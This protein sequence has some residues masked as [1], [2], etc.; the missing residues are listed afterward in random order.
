M[1]KQLKIKINSRGYTD[2]KMHWAVLDEILDFIIS[3]VQGYGVLRHSMLELKD[4]IETLNKLSSEAAIKY[5]GEKTENSYKIMWLALW[6]T[7]MSKDSPE[8]NEK[9]NLISDTLVNVAAGEK[10]KSPLCQN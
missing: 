1:E 4:E 5:M 10:M 3:K 7:Y 9:L 6:E 2:K 8:F